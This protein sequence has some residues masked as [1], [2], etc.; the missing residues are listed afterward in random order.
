MLVNVSFACLFALSCDR[1]SS[2]VIE[3]L[4]L[5]ILL[6][7]EKYCPPASLKCEQKSP[8]CSFCPMLTGHRRLWSGRTGPKCE[9][10]SVSSARPETSSGD[11]RGCCSLT[12]AT[13]E[14]LTRREESSDRWLPKSL[15]QL[16][17]WRGEQEETWRNMQEGQSSS[18]GKITNLRFSSPPPNRLHITKIGCS[19][20]TL[21]VHVD[22]DNQL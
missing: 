20:S 1:A 3:A 10:P 17:H 11:D 14:W 12:T 21:S 2:L 16:G 15:L 4:N 5:K 9:G 8:F 22:G 7:S 13:W 19:V 18:K 6:T